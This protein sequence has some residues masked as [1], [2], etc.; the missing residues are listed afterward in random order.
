MRTRRREPQLVPLSLFG[1]VARG[2]DRLITSKGRFVSKSR[3]DL[4][5]LVRTH[6]GTN[7]HCEVKQL[8]SVDD[9]S[10]DVGR[11][12]YWVPIFRDGVIACDEDEHPLVYRS[13]KEAF[14]VFEARPRRV[15]VGPLSDELL[16]RRYP[17]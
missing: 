12:S 10:L 16:A 11:P 6:P 3:E 15:V 5:Y 1:V 2:G 8:F 4:E 17:R 9:E 14:C 7:R 13:K